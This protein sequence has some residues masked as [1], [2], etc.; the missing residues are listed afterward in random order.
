MCDLNWT[1]QQAH[2]Y[3]THYIRRHP[4]VKPPFTTHLKDKL[5]LLSAI[6][7]M[8]TQEG[9]KR[10]RYF[11]GFVEWIFVTIWLLHKDNKK[12]E[13]KTSL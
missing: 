13:A 9:S 11:T 8:R 10:Q 5:N 7:Q 4:K 12:S 2:E 1:A 3:S 6:T